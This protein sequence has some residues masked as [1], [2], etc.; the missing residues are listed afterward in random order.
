ML[1]DPKR[2][3]MLVVGQP[4]ARL[5]LPL[6]PTSFCFLSNSDASCCNV[7]LASQNQNG[8]SKFLIYLLWQSLYIIFNVWLR[9]RSFVLSHERSF[10][11]SKFSLPNSCSCLEDN[12]CLY[13]ITKIRD[14]CRWAWNLKTKI[15][16]WFSR[17]EHFRKFI[18]FSDT[19]CQLSIWI[20]TDIWLA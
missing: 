8:V 18:R 11:L 5:H 6:P 19:N 16:P 20:N 3:N 4:V 13:V 7:K 17:L 15:A 9:S 14:R 2:W 12:L 10:C 1:L